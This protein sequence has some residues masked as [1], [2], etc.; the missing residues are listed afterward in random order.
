MSDSR[1]QYERDY[2]QI[3]TNVDQNVHS[4][5]E[6]NRLGYGILAGLLAAYVRLD[7]F[8]NTAFLVDH[9]LRLLGP[10][11]I[12]IYQS[13]LG[14]VPSKKNGSCTAVADLTYKE[15]AKKTTGTR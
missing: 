12:K 10:V 1:S 9:S 6:V 5:K 4:A 13:H 11:N 7:D 2:E 3:L 15:S 8:R 14:S